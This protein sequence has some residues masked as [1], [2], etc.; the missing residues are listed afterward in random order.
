VVNP[1]LPT[2]TEFEYL[3][4]VHEDGGLTWLVYPYKCVGYDADT[5]EFI[6]SG[7]DQPV[8]EF[9]TEIDAFKYIKNSGVL[10][11]SFKNKLN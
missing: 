8:L 2:H 10:A 7:K 3:A 5:E 1:D 11:E 9:A 4:S 6:W